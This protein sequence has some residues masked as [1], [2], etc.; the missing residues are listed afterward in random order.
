LE[1]VYAGN[2]IAGSNP[3]SSAKT[4]LLVLHSLLVYISTMSL[5]EDI[6]V[7]SNDFYDSLKDLKDSALD[8]SNFCGHR[9]QLGSITYGIANAMWNSENGGMASLQETGIVLGAMSLFSTY[10]T[11]LHLYGSFHDQGGAK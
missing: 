3:A 4:F 8:A 10:P 2:R 1:S 7:G 11:S 6:H 5:P 9:R